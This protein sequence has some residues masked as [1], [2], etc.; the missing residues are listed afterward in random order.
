MIAFVTRRA[1]DRRGDLEAESFARKEQRRKPE[2]RI[3]QVGETSFDEFDRWKKGQEI[4]LTG[5]K[6]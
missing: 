6:Q 4:A 5:G 2:R 1:G 3:P